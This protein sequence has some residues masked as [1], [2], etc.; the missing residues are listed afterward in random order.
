M[1]RALI[2]KRRAEPADDLISA[3]VAVEAEGD[4]RLTEP[5]LIANAM[6][7]L[8]A[9]HETTTNLVGN[10]VLALLRHP[11]Q[12]QL[13]RDDPALIPTAV[14]ELLRFDGG[15]LNAPRAAAEDMVIGDKN[16]AAGERVMLVLGAANRDPAKFPDADRLDVTRQPNEHLAF[17]VDSHFCLGAHL[18][19]ME[20]QVILA[21]LID[22][23]PGLRLSSETIDWH[24]NP[25]YRGL[26]AL[27]VA[28]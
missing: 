11:D 18:A 17:G 25:A 27:H 15:V 9:G 28:F 5:E 20:A 13:L 26:K 8:T 19:R 4:G 12:L 14:E 24:S 10:G 23:F 22:R 2:A 1:L 7:L 21:S 16:V 6:A 3:L